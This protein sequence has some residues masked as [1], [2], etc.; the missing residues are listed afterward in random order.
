MDPQKLAQLDPKLRDAY[1]RVMGTT[2]PKPQAAPAQTQTPPLTSPNPTPAPQ[3]QQE[4]IPPTPMTASEPFIKPQPTITPDLNQE[5]AIPQQPPAQ[6]SNFV[7]M[8]SEIA[9][10]PETTSAVNSSNFITPP[11]M[12]Q[13]QTMSVKKKGGMMMPILFGIVGLIFIVIYSLFWTKIFN[14]KLPFLP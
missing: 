13:T 14:L 11:T 4:S 1:Q 9:A 10:A 3:P 6:A 8:N 5:A 12:P 7:R 2:I